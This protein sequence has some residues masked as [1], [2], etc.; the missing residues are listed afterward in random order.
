MTLFS[1]LR[2]PLAVA[3]LVAA[4]GLPLA[5]PASAQYTNRWLSAGSYHNWYSEIGGE[6]ETGFGTTQQ[7]FG[8]LWPAI[9]NLTHSQAA[10]GFWIGAKNVRGTDGTTYT[11]RVVHVGPR[12]T[13]ANEFFPVKFEVVSRFDRPAIT[14]NGELT[15]GTTSMAVDRVDPTLKADAMIYTEDNTLL[16][17]TVIRRIYQFSDE[18]HD[19]YHTI[20]TVV[21]NTGN[22]DADSEIELAGQTVSDVVLNW[23]WRWS[24]NHEIR[25]LMGNATGWGKNTMV[26]FRGDGLGTTYGDLPT[27]DFRAMFAWHGYF[28]DKD[29][30]Y[31]NIGAP[32]VREGV[33][34]VNIAASDTLGRL[35]GAQFI[36]AVTLF[37]PGA[38]NGTT[39]DPA[40]PRYMTYFDSDEPLLSNNDAFTLSK[41]EAEYALMTTDATDRHANRISGSPARSS[42]LDQKAMPAEGGSGGKSAAWTY[43]PYTLAPGD[44]VKIVFA[45]GVS[46]L[47]RRN[48]E[49]IGRAYKAVLAGLAG[50]ARNGD[51]VLPVTINGRSGLTKNGWV[52]TGRDSLFQTFR[53]A[54][55]AYNAGYA[56][57]RP[58]LPPSVFDASGGGDR[59]QLTWSLFPGE[60]PQGFELYRSA[61][62]YTQ[63]DTL[64]AT[65]PGTATSYD[66][67]SATRGIGYYYYLRAVGGTT[68]GTDGAPAGRTLKS[69]R[70]W[71]QTYS[72]AVLLRPQG[73]AIERVRIVPNPF[74]LGSPI[75]A[76][77]QTGT[78][79][80]DQG[81]KLGFLD[82]P[83]QCQ[84]E[85]Y[86][87][88]GERI[89]SI[90]HNNGSGDEYWDLATSSRQVVVSGI[91]IAVIT[92][93]EDIDAQTDVYDPQTGDLLYQAGERMYTKG[94]QV[95][96]KFAVIR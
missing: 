37:A 15:E 61:A 1:R 70:Y 23:Q 32:V 49:T 50:D 46:G 17:L 34:A 62:G 90:I 55:T 18:F 86:T 71:T 89:A 63:P 94:E 51:P 93:T 75:N 68:T 20:E 82:L 43:G 88:L 73:V 39:D 28:P 11:T 57:E 60:S 3:M 21:R 52:F 24:V 22:T 16:G 59:I 83:G 95:Y 56:V 85:I 44:S 48:S 35:G 87:E 80:F 25:Y 41:M 84:I 58:P 30:S 27:E 4:V 53:R 47:S 42:F 45:V 76:T 12:A 92:V 77:Q 67:L 7:Q 66:D 81:D 8:A 38:A 31:N 79:Y 14:V 9:Y 36:G 10:S 65:L 2:R 78:R 72:P 33:P 29:R 40:Q 91:Y 64:L 26:D 6:R 69:S 13:G 54:R 19:N 74:Y 5:A 96:R